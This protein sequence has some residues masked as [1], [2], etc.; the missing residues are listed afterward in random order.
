MTTTATK[1]KIPAKDNI[2]NGMEV[3][4]YNTRGEETRKVKLPER[5]FGVSWNADLV[6][7]VVVSEESNKRTPIAHTKGRGDVRGGGR[8]PWRQKGTGRARHGS[9]RS[10]IWKGG[11]VTHGPTKEKSYIKKINKKMRA[12]A[13]YTVLSRKLTDGEILFIDKVLF[14]G[15]KTRVAKALLTTLSDIKGFEGLRTKRRNAVLLALGEDSRDTKRSFRNF[16]NV[17]VE[18]V[19]NL[20]PVDLLTYKY[21]IITDPEQSVKTLEKRLT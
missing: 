17:G 19:R 10:P 18:E 4:V 16:G 5:V 1:K 20:S 11:G 21:V 14:K 2:S 13:L 3:H 9:R 7:Q 6:H 15:P 8:K 12:K